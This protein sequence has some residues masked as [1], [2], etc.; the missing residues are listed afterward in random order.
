MIGLNNKLEIGLLMYRFIFYNPY[1]NKLLKFKTLGV[2]C[3]R[4]CIGYK[5]VSIEKFSRTL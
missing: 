5:S 3:R 4:P 1:Q 2:I